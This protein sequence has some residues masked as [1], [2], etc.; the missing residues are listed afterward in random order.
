MFARS[1]HVE[2]NEGSHIKAKIDG[3]QPFFN[4]SQTVQRKGPRYGNYLGQQT[5]VAATPERNFLKP[6]EEVDPYN[7][8]SR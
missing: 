2:E 7:R 3:I 1:N 5:P 6:I 8:R 4:E